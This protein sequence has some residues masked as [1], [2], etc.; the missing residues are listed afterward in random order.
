[1]TFVRLS[2]LNR[3]LGSCGRRPNEKLNNHISILKTEGLGISA[4]AAQN[5][6][7]SVEISDAV[8][9]G[10][11]KLRNRPYGT[12]EFPEKRADHGHGAR[13]VEDE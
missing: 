9:I 13:N 12:G 2:N 3:S 5:N 1:M 8:Q 7:D 6:A 4:S 11:T 10:G